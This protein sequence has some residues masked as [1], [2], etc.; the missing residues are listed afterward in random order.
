MRPIRIAK[1]VH[2]LSFVVAVLLMGHAFW[3]KA[4]MAM[5]ALLAAIGALFIIRLQHIVATPEWLADFDRHDMVDYG[6]R[7]VWATAAGVLH[8]MEFKMFPGPAVPAF[9]TLGV[10]AA[11]VLV[12]ARR[13]VRG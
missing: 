3:L 7:A 5:A 2:D 11:A 8:T 6:S 10:S 1:A 12:L 13:S 4:N 9:W